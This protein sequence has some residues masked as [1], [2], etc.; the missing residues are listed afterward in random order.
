MIRVVTKKRLN[1]VAA[2]VLMHQILYA[3]V[4]VQDWPGYTVIERP[5]EGPEG[6]TRL[7]EPDPLFGVLVRWRHAAQGG[8]LRFASGDPVGMYARKLEQ[9][10]VTEISFICAGGGSLGWTEREVQTWMLYR[11]GQGT[12]YRIDG[13][14]LFA[15]NRVTGTIDS[16]GVSP[17]PGAL[18]LESPVF[19]GGLAEGAQSLWRATGPGYTGK[20]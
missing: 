4:R 10:C 20:V 18:R 1:S 7:V 11:L 2:G 15:T 14:D 6:W 3:P 19:A 12:L 13:R 17:S 9:R 8:S 16:L 5:A